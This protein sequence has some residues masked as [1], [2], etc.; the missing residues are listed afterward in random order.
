MS[1]LFKLFFCASLLF[2]LPV[3]GFANPVVRE[4]VIMIPYDWAWELEVTVL[5]PDGAGPFPLVVINHG[6]DGVPAREQ[7]RYRPMRAAQEFLKHGFLVVMP[8]RAGFSKSDGAYKQRG[9]DLLKDAVTQAKSIEMTIQFFSKESYV[10]ASRILL[11]GH[12]YGG[13]VSVA[14]GSAYQNAGVKGIINFS[15]GLKN[16][17][18]PCIWDVSLLK[19]FSEFGKKSRTPNLWIYATNDELF[20]ATLANNLSDVY[21]HSGGPLRSVL[22]DSFGGEGHRLFDDSRGVRLW[23]QYVSEFL[24]EIRF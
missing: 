14:Y 2:L 19:A 20:P 18:G 15:G 22:I 8:M 11:V 24:K 6:K 10:D 9:C 7:H 12:S 16:L 13:L 23:S 5:K 1:F 17:S 21:R 4:E 3:S